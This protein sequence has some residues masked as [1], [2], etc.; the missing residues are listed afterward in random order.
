MRTCTRL[1]TQDRRSQTQFSQNT[2]TNMHTTS[3]YPMSVYHR[4]NTPNVSRHKPWRSFCC[5]V[6]GVKLCHDKLA[7]EL[8]KQLSESPWFKRRVRPWP[9]PHPHLNPT[10]SLDPTLGPE[11]DPHPLESVFE[12]FLC[13]CTP[14]GYSVSHLP[15]IPSVAGRF[16]PFICGLTLE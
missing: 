16:W 8:G 3:K 11:P 15:W 10:P 5:N 7:D 14:W 9:N 4:F 6:G 13:P 12:A 2:I 1:P